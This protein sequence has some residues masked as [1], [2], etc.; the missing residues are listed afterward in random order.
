MTTLNKIT[1]TAMHT[2]TT[3]IV[4]CK[5]D[6]NQRPTKNMTTEMTVV[7]TMMNMTDGM[8]LL[9]ATTNELLMWRRQR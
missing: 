5:E 9:A 7:H 4:T 2:T 6:G 8:T 3:A 1:L